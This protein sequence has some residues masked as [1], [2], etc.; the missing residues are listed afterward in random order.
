MTDEDKL[1]ER[2]ANREDKYLQAITKARNA[3]EL[4]SDQKTVEKLNEI[5]DEVEDRLEDIDKERREKVK[6]SQIWA[7]EKEIEAYGEAIKKRKA[8]GYENES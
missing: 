5:Y 6:E 7:L 2:A 4:A 1:E 3:A 8:L